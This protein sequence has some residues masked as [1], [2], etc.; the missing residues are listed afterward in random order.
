MF[1]KSAFSFLPQDPHLFVM[2]V[3]FDGLDATLGLDPQIMPEGGTANDLFLEYRPEDIIQAQGL[4]LGPAAKALVP[5][6]NKCSVI[7]GV[8]M[9][10][11]AG[12][13]PV[14]QYMKTGKGDGT[15]AILPIELAATF[16]VGPYGVLFTGSAYSANRTVSLSTVEDIQRE[17][18][19]TLVSDILKPLEPNPDQMSPLALALR[20][21]ISSRATT[22]KLL[23]A[24]KDIAK[25]HPD[26]SPVIQS[27]LASFMSG[28]CQ[29]AII[30]VSEPGTL[31]THSNH[32]KTHLRYQTQVWSK[33]AD[34]FKRFEKTPF[35]NGSLMDHTTFMVITE[36]SRTPFLNG[37]KGKD[38]NPETNSVLFA[39]KGIQGGKT[40]GSSK[41]I[42]AKKSVTGSPLHIA[43]AIDAKTGQPAQGPNGATFILPENIASSVADI[44]GNPKG[45]WAVDANIAPIPGLKS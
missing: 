43:T 1:G 34:L 30:D 27:L 13:D 17:A 36:F 19:G 5:F 32:E 25:D 23:Q 22:V 15:A 39:G 44:F 45:H 42:I 26:A 8:M 24:L 41:V 31:D 18:S 38:H 28:A 12:H 14:L 20:N 16:G 6:A 3:A 35:M 7:N 40:I 29:Q 37:A 10:R 11:D 21:I 9:K 33:V 2:L 4:K